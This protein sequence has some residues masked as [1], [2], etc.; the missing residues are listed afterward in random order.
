M[1][2]IEQ[3]SKVDAAMM[4]HAEHVTLPVDDVVSFRDVHEQVIRT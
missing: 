4:R 2:K 1:E 3:P